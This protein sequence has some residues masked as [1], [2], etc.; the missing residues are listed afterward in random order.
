VH[1]HITFILKVKKF[2]IP[3]FTYHPKAISP[4]MNN[5]YSHIPTK[6]K[7]FENIL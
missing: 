1:T 2:G 7:D 6:G 4:I 3:H 5:T